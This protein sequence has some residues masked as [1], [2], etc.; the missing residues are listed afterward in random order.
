MEVKENNYVMKIDESNKSQIQTQLGY[1]KDKYDARDYIYKA[2]NFKWGFPLKFN[3][4]GLMPPVLN[5]GNLGSCVSNAVS[6]VL[7]YTDI[8]NKRTNNLNIK[9]YSR[10]F[11][12]YNTRVLENSIFKDNGCQI[13]NAIK[14]INKIGST[15]EKF[16]PYIITKFQDKPNKLSYDDAIKRKITKYRRVNQNQYDIKS[17]INLGYPIIIGILC[18][19]S[20]FTINVSK[21][22]NIPYPKSD[23]Q[24]LGG[25]CIILVGYDDTTQTYE[26]QNSWGTDWGNKGYGKIPYKFVENPNYATDFW[27]IENTI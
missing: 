1:I 5:Q 13:R 15:D 11:N 14:V 2:N 20:M 6:N 16:W 23:Q 3:L 18:F 21:T 9:I 7:R 27:M 22:G 24:I 17:C 10:L 12:Y 4:K 19:S 25:H 8:K 26:F